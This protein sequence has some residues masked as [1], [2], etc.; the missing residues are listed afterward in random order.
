[1]NNMQSN[2]YIFKICNCENLRCV[3]LLGN[4]Y[5]LGFTAYKAASGGFFFDVGLLGLCEKACRGRRGR[6]KACLG[7][8]KACRE[9]P[10][11]L[12]SMPRGCQASL[13]ILGSYSSYVNFFNKSYSGLTINYSLHPNLFVPFK[14]SKFFK[15]ISFII[16]FV[17]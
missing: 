12:P 17:L 1:M 2:Y 3:G 11:T 5:S 6:C 4:S 8:C 15:E 7:H 14:K 9:R 13:H 10:R 16:L